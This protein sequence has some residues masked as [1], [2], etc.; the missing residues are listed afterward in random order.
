MR[1]TLTLDDDVAALLARIRASRKTSF[2]AVVNEALRQ[3]L[4]QMTSPATPHP[5]YRTRSVS[6]GA[7]RVGDLTDIAELLAVGEGDSYR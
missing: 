5:P 3:G 1:T 6:L 7:C 2:K 4:Q